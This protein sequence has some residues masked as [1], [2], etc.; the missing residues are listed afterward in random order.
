MFRSTFN[1][2]EMQNLF[3]FLRLFLS[4]KNRNNY[5]KLDKVIFIICTLILLANRKNNKNKKKTT[6]ITYKTKKTRKQQSG[7]KRNNI[8]I[9]YL[10]PPSPVA[11]LK[12]C[13]Q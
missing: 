3:E 9:C 12:C 13:A 4:V 2:R 8:K 7:K 11:Q 1:F 10:L 5:M 6:T